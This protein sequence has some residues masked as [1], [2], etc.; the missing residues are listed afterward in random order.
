MLDLII[1]NEEIRLLFYAVSLL[2]LTLVT[3]KY[4]ELKYNPFEDETEMKQDEKY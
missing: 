4:V 2:I 1:N 3:E